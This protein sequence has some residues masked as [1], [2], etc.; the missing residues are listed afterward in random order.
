MR[1]ALGVRHNFFTK[2]NPAGPSQTHQ[3]DN[4]HNNLGGASNANKDWIYDLNIGNVMHLSLMNTEDI[5]DNANSN[6]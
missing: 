1:N 4:N 5:N 6:G 3:S 2:G